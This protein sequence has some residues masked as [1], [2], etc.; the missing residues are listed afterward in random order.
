MVGAH[1]GNFGRS[2]ESSTTPSGLF[3]PKGALCKGKEDP[4]VL[5]S[6][7]HKMSG[8]SEDEA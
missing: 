5:E 7:Y 1:T 4:A 3:S 2:E 8:T 6:I